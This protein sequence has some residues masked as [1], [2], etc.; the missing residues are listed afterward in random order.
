MHQIAN[1]TEKLTLRIKLI[2]IPATLL[3]GPTI[4]CSN[5]QKTFPY[6]LKIPSSKTK[7][8]MQS[9]P[10]ALEKCFC[11]HPL[12]QTLRVM[13][14]FFTTRL[15]S[16]A[17]RSAW[18]TLFFCLKGLLCCCFLFVCSFKKECIFN[19]PIFQLEVL[20]RLKTHSIKHQYCVLP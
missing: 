4:E 9:S 16:S 18:S 14:L 11:I 20:Q 8:R 15:M 10:N 1:E 13:Q 5:T 6:S 12:S 17:H 7:T 2:T 3:R 19:T